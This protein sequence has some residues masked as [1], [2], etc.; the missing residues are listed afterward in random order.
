MAIRAIIEVATTITMLAVVITMKIA[1]EIIAFIVIKEVT[2]AVV[3]II[4]IVAVIK[5]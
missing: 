1:V 3:T 4:N 2:F 5:G